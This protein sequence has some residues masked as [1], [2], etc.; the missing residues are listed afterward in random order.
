MNHLEILAVTVLTSNL[1][2][3]VISPRPAWAM[4]P[5]SVSKQQ[6]KQNSKLQKKKKKP[7]MKSHWELGLIRVASLK[8]L[9]FSKEKAGI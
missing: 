2:G 8:G 7:S 9:G 3:R 4:K 5:G 6:T 1:S